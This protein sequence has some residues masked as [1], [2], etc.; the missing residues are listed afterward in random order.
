MTASDIQSALADSRFETARRIGLQLL[1]ANPS[2]PDPDTVFALHDAL[3]KLADFQGARELLEAHRDA[4][5]D[6]EFTLNLVLAQDLST[7]AEEG[8]YR[9]SVESASGYTIDEYKDKYRRLSAERLQQARLLARTPAEHRAIE[10]AKEK[11]PS[12]PYSSPCRI[13]AAELPTSDCGSISGRILF[14]DDRPVADSVVTLGLQVEVDS[15]DPATFTHHSMHFVPRVGPLRKKTARTDAQGRFTISD[16]PHG[17]H[18]FLAVTL[19][20]MQFEIPTRFLSRDLQVPPSGA[21]DVGTLTVEEWQSAPP[22][23]FPSPHP[24]Q[25]VEGKVTWKKCKEWKLRNPFY[26]NFPRQ[27]L[28]LTPPDPRSAYR[29]R[30]TP[31]K[32]H[33]SQKTS[34]NTIA[35]LTDLEAKSEKVIALYTS[36][37]ATGNIDPAPTPA[38]QVDRSQ[39]ATWS[40]S[41]GAADFRIAG[42]GGPATVAPIQAVRGPDQIWRGQG[43][44]LLPDGIHIAARDTEVLDEGPLLFRI[45]QTYSLSNGQQ[46]RITLTAL[47]GERVLLVKEEAEDLPHAAFEFSLREMSGGRGYLHWNAEDGSLH[48]NQLK[49][50]D[51]VIGELQESVA[52]W[53][54]PKGFGYAFTP[55]GL[56]EKDYVGVFTRR[57]GEWIDRLFEKFAQGPIDESGQENREL[58]WPYP[59]MIGSTIS[60]ITAR[61]SQSGDAYFHCPFFDGQRMWGIMVSSFEENDGPWKEFGLTQH[62]YSSPRLQEFKDWHFDQPDQCDRPH[63]IAQRK[64]LIRLR[65]KARSGPFAPLWQKI[66]NEPVPGPREGVQ[67]GIDAD[68]LVAWEK[69]IQ[70]CAI[71]DIRSKM[72]LLGRD[73]SDTF[74]PVGGR[75]ITQWAEEY[76]FLAPSGVFSP[77]EERRVRDFF[78]LMGHLYMEEDFMNWRFN[79]RNANFEADRTDIVGAVGLAFNG[80]PDSAKFTEHVIERTG[81]ALLSYCDENSGKWYENP[82]CYYLHASKCR[83]NL[84]YHLA[85]KG[86]IDLTSIPRLKQFL[87]WGIILLTPPHT[88]HYS[89]MRDGDEQTFLEDDK[90]RKVPPIGDHAGIGKWLS[91]HYAFLGALYKESDP[92]FAR[93]LIDAYFCANADGSRLMGKSSWERLTPESTPEG[94]PF[95]RPQSSAVAGNLPLL[96][97]AFEEED[98]PSNPKVTPPSRRLE[99]FGAVFRNHVNDPRESYLLIKQGPGGYRY[100]RTEG[101]FLW[102]AKGRPLVFDG[103]EAGETWRHSTLSFHDVHMP[104]A[105]GRVERHFESGGIQFLQGAHPVIL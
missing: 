40:V 74:S 26:Y 41:T 71:A 66:C 53:L 97:C 57:R 42:D 31:G 99:G 88:I 100:H 103:G 11:K 91:E 4:L 62:A 73:W 30:V 96:F 39:S 47:A 35:L 59:E 105:P 20:P 55:E 78:I 37:E 14:P 92:G 80:H 81:K 95:Y 12:E 29:L 33:P 49:A 16:V 8:H 61:T 27:L 86:L 7:L 6:H 79:G 69:K 93:E 17:K 24:N 54:P 104:L 94:E 83:I 3:V 5:Q 50:E 32:D 84:I 10:E 67:F 51:K 15:P 48:W 1:E 75:M 68:P 38:I 23:P 76:D 60:M 19:D 43:R 82:A 21:L 85:H 72:S 36:A 22:L 52:W 46:Y 70:F 77:K 18:E 98:I 64:D 87:R 2:T 102:F 34:D 45:K 44:F 65:K 25:F 63:L 13:E 89:T 9:T 101:S 56:E 28:E 58:D 90:V